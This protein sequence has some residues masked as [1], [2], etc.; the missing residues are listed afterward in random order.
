MV[1]QDPDQILWRVAVRGPFG[2]VGLSLIFLKKSSHFFEAKKTRASLSLRLRPLHFFPLW[3]T[4]GG[5]E[6]DSIL[7]GDFDA[8]RPHHRARAEAFRC[9]LS[10][11]TL[12]GRWFQNGR[13]SAGG[14]ELNS[15]EIAFDFGSGKEVEGIKEKEPLE[16]GCLTLFQTHFALGAGS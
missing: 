6:A 9:D 1:G 16:V 11:L 13:L 8:I 10:K 3:L 15:E 14:L 4:F 5:Q 12:L 7:R 2:P